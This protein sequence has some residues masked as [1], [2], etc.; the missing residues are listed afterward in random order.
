MPTGRLASAAK[1]L[2]LA[3]FL[4]P[5]AGG[6]SGTPHIVFCCNTN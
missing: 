4:I 1:T 3:D 5:N 6:Q 2:F